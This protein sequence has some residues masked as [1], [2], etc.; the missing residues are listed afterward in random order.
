MGTRVHMA[1]GY[2]YANFS[3][4]EGDDGV[5]VVDTGFY[6]NPAARALADY[7]KLVKKPIKAIIYPHPC[8][9]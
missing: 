6:S 7:R 1:F 9:L 8:S 4:I 2:D 3:F 5:I